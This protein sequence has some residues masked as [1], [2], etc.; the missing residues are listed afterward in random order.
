MNDAKF[1]PALHLVHLSSLHSAG[2]QTALHQH[3]M[4]F[5]AF[6][7]S[8]LQQIYCYGFVNGKQNH[9]SF[10]PL[11]NPQS[12]QL[13]NSL[14]LTSLFYPFITTGYFFLPSGL[15]DTDMNY[16]V[17]EIIAFPEVYSG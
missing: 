12:Y 7:A 13:F 5:F 17:L 3:K 11:C 16:L 6:S 10:M 9:G 2:V 14:S 4:R 15:F 8:H 1:I